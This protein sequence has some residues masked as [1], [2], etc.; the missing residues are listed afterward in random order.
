MTLKPGSSV[1]LHHK[2]QVGGSVGLYQNQ[3]VSRFYSMIEPNNHVVGLY[4]NQAV[5]RYILKPSSYVPITK[6]K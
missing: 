2:N 1:G 4:Q 5:R 6:A 3:V